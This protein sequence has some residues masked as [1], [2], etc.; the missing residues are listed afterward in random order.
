LLGLFL[1][2]DG[3][4]KLVR[5]SFVV[6]AT[7]RLGYPESALPWIGLVL[8]SCTLLYLVPRTRL[9]GALLLTGYLGGAVEAQ[10]RAGS[11]A[12]ETLFPILVGALVW[13]GA[14]LRDS[15]VRGL[16]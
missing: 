8:I 15:R 1:L 10:V 2:F 16:L 3:A 12:F 4:M 6:E 7:R 14:W 9:F 5:P 13:V 11:S